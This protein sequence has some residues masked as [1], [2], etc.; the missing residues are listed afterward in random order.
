M[1]LIDGTQ[2]SVRSGA[3]FCYEMLSMTAIST[4][5][6]ENGNFQ[7]SMDTSARG[8]VRG[9]ITKNYKFVRYFSPLD[10]QTPTT[11]EELF[12]CNDVQLFD[13][14]NDPEELNNLASDPEANE[15]LIMELNAELNRLIE[16]EIGTDDGAHVAQVVHGLQAV[17]Q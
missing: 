13:M 2:T 5:K 9:L 12:A 10:Y 16:S 11:M 1:P 15:E 3:L 6:D 8:M 17:I 14:K 4:T 7:Y